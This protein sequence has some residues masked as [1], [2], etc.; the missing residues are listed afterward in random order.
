MKTKM[1]RIKEYGFAGIGLAVIMTLI[2][3]VDGKSKVQRCQGLDV[4]MI[5]NSDQFYISKEDVEKFI[6][7]NGQE[8]LEGKLLSE[9][10]LSLLEERVKEIDQVDFCEAYG[11]LQGMLHVEV[12]P[13]IAYARLSTANSNND[14][15]LNETG[16]LFPLSKYHSSRVLLLS[17]SYFTGK[18]NLESKE[19]AALMEL[20]HT[21]KKDDFWN[22]QLAQMDV[23]SSCEI[24]F[25]PVLGNQ[26]IEFGQADNVEQKL[27]KLKVFYKQILSVKGW[28]T[29]STVKLQYANQLVCE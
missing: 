10:N 11:D 18:K 22:A 20:I 23:N 24:R 16:K 13:F 17:G 8:P 9:I 15:Y 27:N 21:I 2:A 7:R 14:R 1:S 28:D 29:F 5:D 19:D 26:T 12:K 4:S 3:F 25:V 6:T